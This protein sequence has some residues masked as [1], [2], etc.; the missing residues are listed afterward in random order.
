MRVCFGKPGRSIWAFAIVAAVA[1]IAERATA[2]ETLRMGGTGSSLGLLEK[3]GAEFT[4]ASGIKVAVIPSLGSSGALRALIDGKLDLAVSAR[5]LKA[6]ESAAGLQQVAVLKT[7]FVLATSKPNPEGLNTSDLPWIFSEQGPIWS[8]GTPIRLILRPRSETD[9]A[10]LGS[11]TPGMDTAIEALRQRPEVPIAATDQD[12]ADLAERMPGSLTG[13]TLTQ[14]KTER[15]SLHAV[16]LNGVAPTFA[17]FE[18]GAYPF[19]KK[20]YLIVR[21]NGAPGALQ[22]VEFLR[23]AAGLKALRE[24]AAL[25]ERE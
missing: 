22:F 1:L 18:S 3:V 25:L 17:N 15:R 14:I 9:N 2:S 12:N 11:I 24:A 4:S 23:S 20:L 21:T 5:P 16:P 10:L 6:D 8:D 13:T 19:A 7:A